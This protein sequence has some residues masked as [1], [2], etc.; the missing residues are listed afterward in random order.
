MVRRLTLSILLSVCTIAV[1]N[2]S[3]ANLITV[4][5]GSAP[6]TLVSGDTLF[7]QSGTYTGNIGGFA[8]GA[9]IIVSDLAT[10]QPTGMSFP[11]VRG[12][13]VIYGSFIMNNN[14]QFRTNSDFTMHNYGTVQINYETLMSGSNQTWTNYA[15]AT[16]N[17]AGNVTMNGLSGD[18]NNVLINYETV[19]TT[20][21]FQMNSGSAIINNK[22]LNVTGTFRVNGGTANNYGKL[23]V[24]GNVL[25]NNGASSIHNYCRMEATNGITNTSGNFY[26]YSYLRAINS[27]IT[28]S[29]NI[30]NARVSN[31]GAPL[32]QP[33]IEGRNFFQS[34]VGT[35]TGPALLY[36]T[37]T[38]SMTNGTIGVPGFTTDTIKM[39]DIT[40]TRPTEILDVQTGG[41][42]HPNV[43][44]NAWGV[45][46]P[47]YV[48]LFGCSIEIL[49][50]IPL[51]I[52]WNNFTVNLYDNVPVLN[53]SA[54]FSS[55]TVFEIQRSYDG[56]NFSTIRD[57]AYEVGRSAYEYKD[58]TVN[59]QLPIVYYRIKANEI[60][61]AQKYT[62]VRTVKFSN[63]PGSIH[64]APNPFT[65]NFIINYNAAEKET[66][67]IRMFNV[68]GQQL[69]M[70]NVT[71]NRGDNRINM[72][73]A[74]N[75]ARGIYVIQ[76]GRGYDMISSSK[77]I[78]Q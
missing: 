31:F 44:Y 37:G 9:T 21:T 13:M 32:S 41:T 55:G 61:G 48:Y 56:R 76:V 70:K 54:E 19:N 27:D 18:L 26:N 42:I 68:S 1:S 30:I 64:T 14:P 69:L 3:F 8:Q 58:I 17:F 49:L 75:L 73:E 47:S 46:N 78:K 43:I 12:T 24:T 62:N 7:I 2:F 36:F 6:Y 16:M 5:G 28:N 72:T 45:P 53:W 10:F 65:N 71:V 39:Y 11:N 50:E 40:R 66:I 35:M 15:G 67:T 29:A 34:G 51:A 57:M 52:N 59:T 33:M 60:S 23:A 22:D 20:G 38:T 63:K 74:A 25:M 4:N 77:I